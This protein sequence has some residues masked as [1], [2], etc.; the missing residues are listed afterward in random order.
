VDIQVRR[1]TAAVN[2]IKALG[3]GWRADELPYDH[4][5]RSPLAPAS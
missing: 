2:L 5:A 4:V 3:G 1:M